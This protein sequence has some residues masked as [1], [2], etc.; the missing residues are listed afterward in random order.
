M[1]RSEV[2]QQPNRAI[3]GEKYFL[4]IFIF[5]VRLLFL[6]YGLGCVLFMLSCEWIECTKG[7]HASPDCR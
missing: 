6:N 5:L 3:T 1:L 2:Q 7:C 4:E